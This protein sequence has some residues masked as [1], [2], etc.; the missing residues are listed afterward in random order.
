MCGT[1]FNNRVREGFIL[2]GSLLHLICQGLSVT[3]S[4]D[5]AHPVHAT[6]PSGSQIIPHSLPAQDHH[7]E[8]DDTLQTVEDIR[9]VPSDI[10]LC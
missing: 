2:H 10:K 3:P 8:D 1:I 4:T 5:K 6:K 7:H 9:H